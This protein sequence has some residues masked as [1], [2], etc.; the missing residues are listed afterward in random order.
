M[1]EAKFVPS[2]AGIPGGLDPKGIGSFWKQH[3]QYIRGLNLHTTG[4]KV[5]T[6]NYT[7]LYCDDLQDVYAVLDELADEG[8]SE[9]P[10]PAE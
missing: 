8:I 6:A 5:F 7:A 1:G 9:E 4:R 3:Q 10:L 2:K